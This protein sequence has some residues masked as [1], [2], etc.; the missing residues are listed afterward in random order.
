[1][2]L[3]VAPRQGPSCSK[4]TLGDSGL[5]RRLGEKGEDFWNFFWKS[6]ERGIGPRGHR[7]IGAGRM[8]RFWG[9]RRVVTVYRPIA[10]WWKPRADRLR[11]TSP[12]PNQPP[13]FKSPRLTFPRAADENRSSRTRK[14]SLRRCVVAREIVCSEKPES[15][16]T[17]PRR[18]EINGT[19]AAVNSS[20]P[21][22]CLP[23][24][25]GRR[26]LPVFVSLCLC[27]ELPRTLAGECGKVFREGRTPAG[28]LEQNHEDT[29]TRR[30][31]GQR[32]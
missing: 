19:S 24:P 1:M 30:H 28:S 2:F 27:V 18:N 6:G 4:R 21:S 29:K 11:S 3:S 31:E 32:R 22:N 5:D 10:S 16:A 20:R 17:T 23:P 26:L 15:H 8:K 13:A 7:M 14:M 12:S 9:A 25:A